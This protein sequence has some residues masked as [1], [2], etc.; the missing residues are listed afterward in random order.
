MGKFLKKTQ[1]QPRTKQ[2]PPTIIGK[3][4]E[5]VQLSLICVLCILWHT[6]LK[7][8]FNQPLESGTKVSNSGFSSST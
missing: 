7:H 4:Q 6:D 2:K 3:T 8:S 5:Q 1:N